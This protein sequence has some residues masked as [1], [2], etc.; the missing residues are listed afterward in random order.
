VLAGLDRHFAQYVVSVDA[1]PD[2]ARLSPA[3]V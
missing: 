3:L 2:A 1:P